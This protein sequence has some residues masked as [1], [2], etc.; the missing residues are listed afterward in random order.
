MLASV[1]DQHLRGADEI[2]RGVGHRDEG[3][4]ALVAR[5]R[6]FEL[7]LPAGQALEDG[8]SDFT[9]TTLAIAAVE[10]RATATAAPHNISFA[11]IPELLFIAPI[12]VAALPT[13]TSGESDSRVALV[14]NY[15]S[16]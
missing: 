5:I 1:L 7:V 9:T 16:I 15:A 14:A 11:R 6:P 2:G 12:E 8:R 10:P 3:H 13:R 4:A